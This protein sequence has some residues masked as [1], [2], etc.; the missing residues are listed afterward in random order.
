MLKPGGTWSVR[1]PNPEAKGLQTFGHYWQ[2][3]EPPRHIYL[4]SK[5]ALTRLGEEHGFKTKVLTDSGK[6]NDIL[7]SS[8]FR[9]RDSQGTILDTILA[10]PLGGKLLAHSIAGFW[11]RSGNG[12]MLNIVFTKPEHA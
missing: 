12:D 2:A 4:Y 11:N 8:S 1:A 3:L 5:S 10:I 7:L 9:R 6:A